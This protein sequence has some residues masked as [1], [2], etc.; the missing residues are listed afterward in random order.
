MMN[1]KKRTAY[2]KKAVSLIL[3]LFMVF[4]LVGCGNDSESDAKMTTEDFGTEAEVDGV[5]EPNQEIDEGV[6]LPDTTTEEVTTEEATSEEQDQSSTSNSGSYTYDVDG[7][8]V[9]LRTNIDDYIVYSP[10]FGDY[11]VDLV[12]IAKSIGFEP[13]YPSESVTEQTSFKTSGGCEVYLE[14]LEDQNFYGIHAHNSY[15]SAVTFNFA[16]CDISDANKKTYWIST[17]EHAIYKINYEQ[18]I[19]FTLITENLA[20]AESEDWV[21]AAGFIKTDGKTSIYYINR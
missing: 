10:K 18:I 11:G 8:T 19:I 16:R 9:T 14:K 3:V 6:L 5:Q 1:S 2:G 13:S 20:F 17:D 7:I 15:G 12:G 4:A 21:E